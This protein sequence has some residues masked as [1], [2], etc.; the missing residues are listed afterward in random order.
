MLY[1]QYKSYGT[2]SFGLSD[3]KCFENCIF[4]NLLFD[5][6]T[7][8]CSVEFGRIPISCLGEEVVWIFPYTRAGRNR[9]MLP[10]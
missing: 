1:T 4:K 2:C 5:P 7:Y 3:K 9:V 8:L 6:V 10:E